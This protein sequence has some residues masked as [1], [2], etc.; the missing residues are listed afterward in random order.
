M[1]HQQAAVVIVGGGAVGMTLALL[2]ESYN[3]PV[4]LMQQPTPPLE[5][6]RRW[7]SLNHASVTLLEKLSVS[8]PLVP[9]TSM[10]VFDTLGGGSFHYRAQDYGETSLGCTV[11]EKQLLTALEEA[12]ARSTVVR[13]ARCVETHYVDGQWTC[14]DNEKRRCIAPFVVA[15]DGS[16]SSCLEQGGWRVPPAWLSARQDQAL[17]AHVQSDAPC[18][19][20]A[21][22]WFS[23]TDVVALLPDDH[24]GYSLVWTTPRAAIL[25]D[26]PP[27]VWVRALEEATAGQ[28]GRL[29]LCS[30]R[31]V[32]PLTLRCARTIY[33]HNAALVGNAACTL[34]PLAGQGLNLAYWTLAQMWQ[35]LQH[36]PSLSKALVRWQAQ[37]LPVNFGYWTL[38]NQIR[39]VF[40]SR[41]A[42]VI[43]LRAALI[44][45]CFS[46]PFPAALVTNLAMHGPKLASAK[47]L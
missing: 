37:V 29:R 28:A 17:I 13:I 33:A 34:H 9:F 19:A 24:N 8:V 46:Q 26:S 32:F 41:H 35:C 42:G 6:V 23:D 43:A 38:M 4:V 3:Q 15:A 27:E 10:K 36:S 22:Q 47:Q 5:G 7:Y 25:A 14:V 16:A 30:D 21:R 1:T 44:R 45:H 18:I 39:R 31:A 11:D 40:C 2:L 20:Q 12:V